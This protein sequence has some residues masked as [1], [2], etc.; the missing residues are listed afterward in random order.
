MGVMGDKEH[1]DYERLGMIVGLVGMAWAAGHIVAVPALLPIS[2]PY[3]PSN[4]FLPINLWLSLTTL[5]TFAGLSHLLRYHAHTPQTSRRKRWIQT[6]LPTLFTPAWGWLLLS[7][8]GKTVWLG[9]WAVGIALL[10]W[11][12][13]WEYTAPLSH[14]WEMLGW[15]ELYLILIYLTGLLWFHHLF[16]RQPVSF[17]SLAAIGGISALLVFRFGWQLNLGLLTTT[18]YAGIYGLLMSQIAWVL[19]YWQIS[20]Q[21]KSGLLLIPFFLMLSVSYQHIR[22]RLTRFSSLIYGLVAAGIFLFVLLVVP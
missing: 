12:L 21:Q 10:V 18:L 2:L 8:Q 9:A 22:K 11:L 16:Q 4:W 7:L 19:T 1:L 14:W 3:L 6:I 20:P 13:V 15:S 17:S 5:L